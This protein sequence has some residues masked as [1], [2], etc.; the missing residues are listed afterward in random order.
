MHNH[1]NVQAP[2]RTGAFSLVP[3]MLFIGVA[4]ASFWLATQW[5]AAHLGYQTRLGP[6]IFS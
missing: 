2:R 5:T 1:P 6:G 3:F 4:M